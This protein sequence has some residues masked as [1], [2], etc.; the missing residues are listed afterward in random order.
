MNKKEEKLFPEPFKYCEYIVEDF[1]KEADYKFANMRGFHRAITKL[2][3]AIRDNFLEVNYLTYDI[4]FHGWAGE[5]ANNL[6]KIERDLI[7]RLLEI[8]VI[9]Q[10][11][12]GECIYE[13]DKERC[14]NE[15]KETV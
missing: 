2:R 5:P 11:A 7:K 3:D 15:N 9:C 1:I 13:T 8:Y 14:M 10:M 12:L 4:E 6:K